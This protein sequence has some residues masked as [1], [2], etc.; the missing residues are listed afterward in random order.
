MGKKSKRTRG[1]GDGGSK[2]RT[3]TLSTDGDGD[4]QAAHARS[5]KKSTASTGLAH[6]N[7]EETADNLRFEDP[8]EDVYEEED[9]DGADAAGAGV[10]AAAGKDAM[11]EDDD[12]VGDAKAKYAAALKRA[13]ES[14]GDVVLSWNPLTCPTPGDADGGELEMDE[15]A[16]AMHHALRPEWPSLSFAFLRDGLGDGRTR[17]PHSCVAAVGSQAGDAGSKG[18]K[19]RLTVVRMTDLGR[20]YRKNP[21]EDD[22][23]EWGSVDSDEDSKDEEDDEL[24]DDDDLDLDPVLE[25]YNFRHTG[26]V[27][28]IRAM[29]QN[30]SVVATWS[31]AGKVNLYDVQGVLDIFDASSGR[32]KAASTA[33]A[34]SGGAKAGGGGY[35]KDPF[36]VYSGHSTEGYALDWSPVVPGRLATGDCDGNV[37]VWD[38]TVALS[39]PAYSPSNRWDQSSFG[40]KHL[41]GP[42][43]GSSDGCSNLDNPSVEDVQWSP[44]EG[45][46]LA[47][48]ECGGYVK[49]YDIR[50]PG[51][52]MIARKIHKNGSDVNVLAWNANVA[53][54]LASGGD[55]GTFCVWDL[56]TFQSKAGD[57]DEG[58]K[59]LARFSCHK[60]PITSVEWHPTDESMIAVSDDVGT[61]VYDL[62]VEED[63]DAGT[64]L[65]ATGMG[66]GDDNDDAGGIPPQ[67][68]FLHAGSRH[69]KEV[70]WHP[71]VPSLLMTTSQSGYNVFIPSNL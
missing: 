10:A 12:A 61:Y 33:E 46:V 16:Y 68:L 23:D 13:A 52:A 49:V 53:N 69:T 39:A 65:A 38:P 64:V 44:T 29:P 60:T 19:N 66:E 30:P 45:T 70:H 56:R 32:G 2:A 50:C 57:E 62:S 4:D 59:P 7:E 43:K 34:S 9:V 14:D 36:F 22:D 67:L 55:D 1:G 58:P 28:R 48:A 11:D 3:P 31:D 8:Y 26:C 41:Y 21:D 47:A 35:R 71:Q 17:F 25:H 6:V 20:T 40:V 63:V 18:D 15:S 24:D 51:K 54:L 37:H 42:S 27:N 5:T